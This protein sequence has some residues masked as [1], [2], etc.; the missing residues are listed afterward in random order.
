[1]TASSFSPRSLR[2]PARRSTQPQR[3]L[4]PEDLAKIPRSRLRQ[5]CQVLLTESGARVVE[6]NDPAAYDELVLE[7]LPLWRPRRVR[8]RIAARVIK[9]SDI[10]RLADR[11]ANAGDADGVLI[12]PLGFAASIDQ[13]PRIEIVSPDLL[14]SRLERSA[15][16]AWPGRQP[17]PAYDRVGALRQLEQDTSL[18]DSIG[19]RWLPTLALNELPPELFSAA[20]APQD[21]LERM[22]FRLMTALFRFGGERAGEAERGVRVPD[23]TLIWPALAPERLAALVDCKAA[24][25][26]YKMT[27]DHVLRF[28]GYIESSRS[29]ISDLGADLRYLLVVSSEFPGRTGDRHRFAGRARELRDQTGVRLVYIRAVDLARIA[30]MIESIELSPSERERLDWR[31]VFDRGLVTPEDLEQ[32]VD[33]RDKA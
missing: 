17:S 28:K 13:D 11:V 27:S 9:Q 7:V 31:S 12:A 19:I 29:R 25:D 23:S 5:L 8:V 6:F 30:A 20:V 16:I 18:I 3:Q 24:G 21:L 2:P 26:G 32:M 4:S 10:A 33:D 22:V 14:I 1:M 15:L